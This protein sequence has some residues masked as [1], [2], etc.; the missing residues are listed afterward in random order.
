MKHQ[1]L[2]QYADD[3]R[4]IVLD[5]TEKYTAILNKLEQA[6]ADYKKVAESAQINSKGVPARR[7][8]ADKTMKE[9]ERETRVAVDRLQRDM[10]Q[11]VASLRRELERDLAEWSSAKPEA[12]DQE[13]LTL[14]NSGVLGEADFLALANKH[15]ASPTM[16]RLIA[17]AAG[18]GNLSTL[19]SRHLSP[20][21]RLQNF[22]IAAQ[23]ALRCVDQNPTTANVYQDQW[24]STTYQALQNAMSSSFEM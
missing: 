4:E 8:A 17:N 20:T 5:S 10:D 1:Y 19:I 11:R 16:L 9:A 2:W 21:A 22:D 7:M 23:M 15:K 18:H 3:L 13:T 14:L 24:S 6:R 12:I